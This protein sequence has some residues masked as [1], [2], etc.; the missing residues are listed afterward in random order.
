MCDCRGPLPE[1]TLKV[2]KKGKKQQYPVPRNNRD[3]HYKMFNH[4][5]HFLPKLR[6][7]DG[8]RDLP[9]STLIDKFELCS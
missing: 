6:G 8:I 4:E 2:L 3:V 5:D 1:S 7:T 9:Y